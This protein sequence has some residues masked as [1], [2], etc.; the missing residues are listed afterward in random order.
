M[1]GQPRGNE[2]SL[3]LSGRG[4]SVASYILSSTFACVAEL[5]AIRPDLCTVCLMVAV[6]SQHKRRDS[7]E[8]C[9]MV[10]HQDFIYRD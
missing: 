4:A 7:P 2:P 5:C 9:F 8:M 3:N 10:Q 6:Y 1:E